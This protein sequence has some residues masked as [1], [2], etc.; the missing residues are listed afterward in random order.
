[1]TELAEADAGGRWWNADDVADV[2]EMLAV[3][4][5]RLW[6]LTTPR[7]PGRLG[8]PGSRAVAARPGARRCRR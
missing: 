3:R 8:L 2:T 5:S 6:Q 1:M 4:R 7:R